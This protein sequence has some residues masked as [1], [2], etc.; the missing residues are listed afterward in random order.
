MLTTLARVLSEDKSS[1]SLPPAQP[2]TLAQQRAIMAAI[3]KVTR[4]INNRLSW[5]FEPVYG[6]EY[7]TAWGDNVNTSYA[8]LRLYNTKGQLLL[9]ASPTDLPTITNNGGAVSFGMDATSSPTVLPMPQGAVP[10]RTI[11][12]NDGNGA[13]YNNWWWPCVPPRLD[14]IVITGWWGYASDFANQW[15]SSNDTIQDVG[16]I[17]ASV[18]TVT[19][20]SVDGFDA[21]FNTPRFSPGNLIRID[22]ELLLVMV[23]DD[24]A[25]TL[26]VLR[27]QNGTTATS[28]A[29][30]A[31]INIWYPQEDVMDTVSRQA[32][33]FYARRGAYEEQYVQNVA[34]A[35]Y[36]KDMVSELLATLQAYNNE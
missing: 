6:T 31:A 24:V 20:S 22:S 27:G 9:L 32:A 12:F 5:S 35:V 10:I 29:Q 4:R 23:T 14:S 25:N 13:I 36:P 3:A 17:N 8:M 15:V 11:R 18:Q 7:I 30:N 1:D 19:V 2:P 21:R 26:S 28:H 34:T 33:Y 16:G